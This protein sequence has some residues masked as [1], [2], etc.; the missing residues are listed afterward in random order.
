[1]HLYGSFQKQGMNIFYYSILFQSYEGVFGLMGRLLLERNCGKRKRG[2]WVLCF[3]FRVFYSLFFFGFS[4]LNWLNC[5]QCLECGVWGSMEKAKR[6]EREGFQAWWGRWHV[7][8]VRG[9]WWLGVAA[10]INRAMCYLLSYQHVSL[11]PIFRI[12]NKNEKKWMNE[13]YLLSD[14]YSFRCIIFFS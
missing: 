12:E 9:R 5:V 8:L 11:Y 2:K 1:M 4:L 10:M 6:W 3:G 14:S 13:S 7:R